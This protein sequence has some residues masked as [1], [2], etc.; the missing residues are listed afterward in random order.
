LTPDS[1]ALHPGYGLIGAAV[2]RTSTQARQVI[3]KPTVGVECEGSKKDF[4]L[5]SK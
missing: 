5:R 1:A 3:A 4:S 2:Q